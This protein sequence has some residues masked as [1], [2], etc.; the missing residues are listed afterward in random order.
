[1]KKEFEECIDEIRNFYIKPISELTIEDIYRITVIYIE[2]TSGYEHIHESSYDRN[3]IPYWKQI[4]DII[5]FNFGK[6]TSEF[7][8]RYNDVI[9]SVDL[10]N[11]NYVIELKTKNEV[12]TQDGIQAH[13][14]QCMLYDKNRENYGENY[15]EN[16]MTILLNLNTR[17]CHKITSNRNY[18]YWLYITNKFV[19]ITI[20]QAHLNDIISNSDQYVKIDRQNIFCVDTEFNPNLS[21][22]RFDNTDPNAIFEISIFNYNDPFRSILQVVNNTGL[23]RNFA[24]KWLEIDEKLYDESPNIL[25]VK[26]MFRKVLQLYNDKPLL[27]YYIAKMDVSWSCDIA[28]TY[29]LS[30]F[31]TN[32]CLRKGTLINSN[33]AKLIDYYNSHVDFISFR[34]HLKPH[35]ALSDTIMLYEIMKTLKIQDK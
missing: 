4:A 11:E 34:T 27:Y 29:D 8:I 7:K 30:N 10:L 17:T 32:L 15:G 25:G 16:R 1:M 21:E 20:N 33:K 19:E 35:T 23:N 31:I 5:T 6:V 9:G 3:L 28:D 26:R 2:I 22:E 12:E 13:L 24:V 18:E 14:Y